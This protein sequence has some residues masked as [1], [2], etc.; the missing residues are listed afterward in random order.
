MST[1]L[2]LGHAPTYRAI[3]KAMSSEFETRVLDE[4]IEHKVRTDQSDGTRPM[5]YL[6]R[7]YN[8]LIHCTFKSFVGTSSR[9][10]M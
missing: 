8:F 7:S 6:R 4:R 2:V 5:G 9:I 1:G 10:L 3:T